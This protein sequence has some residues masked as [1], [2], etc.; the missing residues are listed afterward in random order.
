MTLAEWEKLYDDASMYM[1]RCGLRSSKVLIE[2]AAQHPLDDGRPGPEFKARLDRAIELTE[3][4]EFPKREC[5]FWVP[6]VKHVYNGVWDPCSLSEAG[7][8]YLLSQG[9]PRDRIITQEDYCALGQPGAENSYD[10]TAAAVDLFERG[11]CGR[12]VCVCSSA[13]APRKA[14]YYVYLGYLP[15]VYGV[16]LDSMHHSWVWEL[17]VAIPKI[18][19]NGPGKLDFEV[20][21]RDKHQ[22]REVVFQ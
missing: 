9:V 13:Q 3:S 8:G 14:L 6:G 16:P 15:R 17:A 4:G 19:E 2:V 21:A 20:R 11:K 5:Y 10:E 18:L 1:K 7:T 22:G 12:L